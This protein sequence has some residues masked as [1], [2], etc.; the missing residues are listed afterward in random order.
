MMDYESFFQEHL[1]VLVRRYRVFAG[2]MAGIG[3]SFPFPLAPTK[4]S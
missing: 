1:E 4:V 3:A 2:R